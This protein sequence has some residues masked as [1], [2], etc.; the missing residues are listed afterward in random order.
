MKQRSRSFR[1]ELEGIATDVTIQRRGDSLSAQLPDAPSDEH[2]VRLLASGDDPLLLIGTRV[3]ALSVA[4]D[5]LSWGG[6]QVEH[7]VGSAGTAG[8]SRAMLSGAGD[9]RAPM[10]GRVVLIRARVG[11]DVT[12]GAPLVVIEAMKMQNELLAPRT[13]KVL[14]IAVAEGDTVERGATLVELS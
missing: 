11:D 5:E 4:K 9:V 12:A 2:A 7:W 1:V 14:R 13:G 3:V 10:P 8:G 6:R